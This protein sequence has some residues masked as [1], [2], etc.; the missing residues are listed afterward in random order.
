M[1]VVAAGGRSGDHHLC[2]VREKR[3]KRKKRSR[4]VVGVRS[5]AVLGMSVL[6]ELRATPAM[7]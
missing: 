3:K 6:H 5:T 4:Q 2:P 1:V 7:A